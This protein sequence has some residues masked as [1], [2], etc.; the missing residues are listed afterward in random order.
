MSVETRRLAAA[1]RTAAA[2]PRARAFR[3]ASWIL[4][5]PTLSFFSFSVVAGAR[6]F[7]A[8]ADY[9]AGAK[10]VTPPGHAKDGAL[11]VVQASAQNNENP[12]VKILSASTARSAGSVRRSSHASRSA[13]G[14]AA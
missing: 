3:L 13:I 12:I 9:A 6:G 10:A 14:R 2:S 11:V 4:I 7:G 5:V 8:K 1:Q